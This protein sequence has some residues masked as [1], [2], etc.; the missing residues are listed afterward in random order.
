MRGRRIGRCG[1]ALAVAA[2][3]VCLCAPSSAGAL[4]AS[5]GVGVAVHARLVDTT[6]TDQS[7]T[8]TTVAP[9]TT[10]TAPTTTT[11]VAPTTST[12]PHT[13]TSSTRV[14]RSTTTTTPATNTSSSVPVGLIVL[15]VVLVLLIIVVIVLLVRRRRL[16]AES[17]WHRAVTPA[18]ADAQLARQSLLSGNA[19]SPDSEV[20]G[21]VGLQAERAATALDQAARS[22]PDD[23][24]ADLTTSAANSLRGLAFAVE[25]DRLLRAGTAAPTGIQL[26]EADEAKRTRDAELRTALARLSTRT[27][28]GKRRR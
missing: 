18:L 14:P 24:A 25:A 16:A 23:E 7:T 21:A 2:V 19:A 15:I 13:T 12:V 9:T 26:A 8:T 27:S 1:P 22:A 17:T 10:T 3:S 20:R 11:T 4:S 5:G 28:S 6:T